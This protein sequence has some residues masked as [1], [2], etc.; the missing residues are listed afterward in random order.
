MKR[1]D[2]FPTLRSVNEAL[3]DGRGV[4]VIQA[5]SGAGFTVYDADKKVDIIPECRDLAGN[6]AGARV[7]YKNA[8]VVL[9]TKEPYSCSKQ[10]ASC[11]GCPGIH[12]PGD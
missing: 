9:I 12:C 5:I 8:R 10:G 1:G 2:R 4:V 7:L 3:P 11:A 6:M